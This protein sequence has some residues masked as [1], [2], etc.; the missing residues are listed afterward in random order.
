VAFVGIH[1]PIIDYGRL[2]CQYPFKTS[3]ARASRTTSASCAR[4]RGLS[5]ISKQVV[6]SRNIAL[7]I[8]PPASALFLTSFDSRLIKQLGF[9]EVQC[10]RL[11]KVK[12]L[13]PAC[14]DEAKHPHIVAINKVDIN[15]RRDL[16][17]ISQ[18]KSVFHSQTD[19]FLL[20][21]MPVFYSWCNK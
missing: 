6:I 5:T 9:A 14:E 12:L 13:K 16:P 7:I 18:F 15:L 8:F 19:E 20:A 11:R 1:L 10:V 3:I 4:Q 17:T 21:V 2:S